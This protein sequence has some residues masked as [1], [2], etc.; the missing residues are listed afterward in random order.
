MI[1][2]RVKVIDMKHIQICIT[3]TS[4]KDGIFVTDFDSTFSFHELNMMHST[5]RVQQCFLVTD[6]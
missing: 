3:S 6:C 4:P 5:I 2:V 1:C